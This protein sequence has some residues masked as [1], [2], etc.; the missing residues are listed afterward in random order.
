M[1]IQDHVDEH[2]PSVKAYLGVFAALMALTGVTVGVAFLDLG[3]LNNLVALGIAVVKAMLVIAVFMHLKDSA[4]IL[5]I[6]AFAGFLWLAVL[7]VLS[8]S[9]VMSRGWVPQPESWLL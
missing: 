2:E 4:R 3:V 1:S 5:W 6:V 7:L 8:M 9:D